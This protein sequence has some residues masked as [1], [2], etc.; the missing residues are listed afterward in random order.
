VSDNIYRFGSQADDEEPTDD[1]VDEIEEDGFTHIGYYVRRVE[2]DLVLVQTFITDSDDP[3]TANART[4][5]FALTDLEPEWTVAVL[6]QGEALDEDK[7]VEFIPPEEY[8]DFDDEE[9]D[10]DFEEEDDAEYADEEEDEDADWYED[11]DDE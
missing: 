6:E 8:D 3:D 7:S 11:E 1:D 2:G 10:A 5:Y 9:D 4:V